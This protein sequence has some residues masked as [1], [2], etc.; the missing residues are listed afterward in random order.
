M[1]LQTLKYHVV[2]I[3]VAGKKINDFTWLRQYHDQERDQLPIALIRFQY[4]QIELRQTTVSVSV[5][6]FFS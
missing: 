5:S 4:V 2:T 3:L 6:M 1:P